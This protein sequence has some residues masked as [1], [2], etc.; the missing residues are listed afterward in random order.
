MKRALLVVNSVGGAVL[1]TLA[2]AVATLLYLMFSMGDETGRKEGL[3]GSLFFE[4]AEVREG[5]TG[6]TMGVDNPTG[7]FVVFVF[8]FLFLTS[9]QLAYLG[10]KSRRDQLL[11]ER[12]HI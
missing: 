8:F 6:A 3:F 9:T 5:V 7:I 10:L 12:A 11:K 1:L 2:T 4:A